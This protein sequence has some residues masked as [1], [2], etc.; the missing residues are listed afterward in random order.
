[1]LASASS[2]GTVRLWNV[3]SRRQLGQP[4]RGHTDRVAGIAF[5]PD[6]QILAFTS[7]DGTVRLWD[8]RSRQALG[9]PLPGHKGL[10]P[11][12]TFSKD[13][14]TLAT[15]GADKTARLWQGFLW[16]DFADLRTMVCGL[17]WGK[18]TKAEWRQIVPGLP[19]R[20]TCPG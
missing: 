16:D 19:Y 15:G 5:S 11:A 1:M 13:G 17:V 12:I 20:T 6:G 9:L 8:V 14:R 4:L 7:S 10:V 18:L 3:E 2:D